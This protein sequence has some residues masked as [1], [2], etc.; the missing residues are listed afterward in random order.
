ML[1][2]VK[3]RKVLIPDQKY[4]EKK[5][6]SCLTFV[7]VFDRKHVIGVFLN[8]FNAGNIYYNVCTPEKDSHV[9]K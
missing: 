7:V 5:L 6:I 2:T 8:S 4:K 1:N 9:E 3:I